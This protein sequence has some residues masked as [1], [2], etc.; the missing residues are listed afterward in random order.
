MLL[1]STFEIARSV[2]QLNQASKFTTNSGAE[3]PKATI[4]R[5]II[6]LDIPNFLATEEAHST[7]ISAHFISII[8]HKIRL[9]NVIKFSIKKNIFNNITHIV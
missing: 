1:Q 3:V 9:Q 6:R 5:P 2:S 4:V 8:N 7:N